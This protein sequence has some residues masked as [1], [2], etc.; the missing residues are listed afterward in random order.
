MGQVMFKIHRKLSNRRK[1]FE[2][3]VTVMSTTITTNN[4]NNPT[5]D[6]WQRI[7]MN[8]I[9]K[10]AHYYDPVFLGQIF[11]KELESDSNVE[12]NGIAKDEL[13]M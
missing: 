2:T 11:Y 4:N 10:D 12:V 3:D 5:D 6:T 9:R 7:L 8:Q 13:F 1:F